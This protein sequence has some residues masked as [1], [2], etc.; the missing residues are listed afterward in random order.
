MIS[1]SMNHDRQP[2]GHLDSCILSFVS[3]LVIVKRARVLM[4][5][6]V[7]SEV[8]THFIADLVTSS[9]SYFSTPRKNSV[10]FLN[11]RVMSVL[12]SAPAANMRNSFAETVVLMFL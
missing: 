11:S 10:Q 2:E 9:S 3:F 4:N 8:R 12:S 5:V 1:D 6:G 7:K